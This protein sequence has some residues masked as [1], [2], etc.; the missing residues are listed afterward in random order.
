[1]YYG[2]KHKATIQHLHFGEIETGLNKLQLQN[3]L[4]IPSMIRQSSV[5]L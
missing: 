2:V 1:M 4:I 3:I 5:E